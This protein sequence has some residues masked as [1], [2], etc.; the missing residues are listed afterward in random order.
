MKILHLCLAN[1]YIDNFSY[2]ENLLPKYHKKLGYEV[3]IIASNVT[4]DKEGRIIQLNSK[5]KEYINENNIP[6]TRLEHKKGIIN[7]KLRRYKGTLAS[8]KKSNPDV[9]FI[10]GCQFL[11]IIEV[12]KF[13][14]QNTTVT[15]YVDNHADYS[16]SAKNWIS[17][18]ILHKVI[19]KYC[20]Q[21]I[22]PFTNKFYGVLPNRVKFLENVYKVPE[23]KTELLVM[24][25]D[26][27][28]LDNIDITRSIS[29][30]RNK[31]DIDESDFLIVTGGKFTKEKKHILYLLEAIQEINNPKIKL[32][33]F[34]SIESEF[35]KQMEKYLNEPSVVFVGWLNVLESNLHFLASD[36]VVFP[37]S[38][39]VYWEQAVGLG[40]PIIVRNWENPV[41]LDIGGNCIIL[42]EGSKDEI[43]SNIKSLVDNPD[44]FAKM[45]SAAL[46]NQK[47][48][49]LYSNIAKQSLEVI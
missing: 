13:I 32:V 7:N 10:H 19:W 49:F 33:I 27:E 30:I 26:D 36:L 17:K 47:D 4:F 1:F 12:V 40:K 29:K 45:N 20:A 25:V 38:H 3:E 37:S 31:Y 39:S 14:K 35:K 48:A 41:H 46:S 43:I 22:L 34:G 21:K 44:V 5:F 15:I 24:G 23:E 2:Q 42:K 9:I 18:N 11:D 28:I 8:I 6:V 16:N